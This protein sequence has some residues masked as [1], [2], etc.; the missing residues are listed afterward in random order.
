MASKVPSGYKIGSLCSLTSQLAVVTVQM[1][2]H[3]VSVR[4][5]LAGL[6]Q[7]GGDWQESCKAGKLAPATQEASAGKTSCG[8]RTEGRGHSEGLGCMCCNLQP[9]QEVW[10]WLPS[11]GLLAPRSWEIPF[12]ET[13]GSAQGCTE[14]QLV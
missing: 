2:N 10:A 7:S 1:G 3:G 9:P 4:W 13:M 8:P 14:A 6:D 12:R 5:P 11:P